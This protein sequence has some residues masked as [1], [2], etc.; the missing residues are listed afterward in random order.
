MVGS[1]RKGRATGG[2]ERTGRGSGSRKCFRPS[3]AVGEGQA[4]GRRGFAVFALRPSCRG[5]PVRLESLTYLPAGV[6]QCRA[7]RPPVLPSS[8]HVALPDFLAALRL[9]DPAP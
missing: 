1:P 5:L 6:V 4:R 2:A 3:G 7:W 9:A 8:T